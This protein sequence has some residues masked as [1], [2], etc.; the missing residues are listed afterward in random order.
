VLGPIL[1]SI[2]MLPLALGDI[3]RKF[4]LGFHCY[5]DD[6]QI[7]I[8][9]HPDPNLAVTALTTWMEEIKVWM[10]DN[11]LK[12]NES[13]TELLFVGTPAGLLTFNNSSLI[14]DYDFIT[15]SS[16]V[17]NLG[18]IFDPELMFD[19]HIKMISKTAFF[20]LRNISRLRSSLLLSDLFP[21]M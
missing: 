13:K 2:Y 14:T 19:A 21:Q 11:F 9:M 20:H 12:L 5:A 18:V 6:T 7:Y 10:N 8:S 1:F 3:I 17:H 16:Q 4:G 15:P